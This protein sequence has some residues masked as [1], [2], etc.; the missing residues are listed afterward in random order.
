MPRKRVTLLEYLYGNQGYRKGTK[1]A[2]FI[3]AWGLYSDSLGQDQRAHMDGYSKYWRQ[4]RASSY[5]E[6]AVFHEVFP[7]ELP[8]RLWGLI[9]GAVDSRKLPQAMAQALRVESVWSLA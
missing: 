2:A 5:R 4:S 6:L 8:D 7:D 9:R 1:S 3:V